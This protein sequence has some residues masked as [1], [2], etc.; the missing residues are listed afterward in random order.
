MGSIGVANRCQG[1]STD[2]AESV[3]NAKAANSVDLGL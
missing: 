3:K 2:R 1:D